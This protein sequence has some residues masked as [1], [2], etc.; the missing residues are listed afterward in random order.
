M[1][2]PEAAPLHVPLHVP[3]DSEQLLGALDRHAVSYVLI[4]GLGA[5]AYGFAEATTDVDITPATTRENLRRLAKA[6]TE[7]DARLLL[8]ERDRDRAE[9]CDF[10]FDE[11][12][13]DAFQTVSVRTRHGDLDIALR[14]DAPKP[15]GFFDYG[16]LRKN[17][18]EKTAF[19]L[20]IHVAALEDIIASKTAAGRPRDLAKLPGL[21]SLLARLSQTP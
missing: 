10:R 8:R 20:R 11:H 9:V 6:L 19:G 16:R 15:Q 5:V 3:L 2:E 18:V 13:F 14:P 4:G 17:A 1:A 12:A 21:R 7:M